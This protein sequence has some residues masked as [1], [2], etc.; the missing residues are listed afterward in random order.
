MKIGHRRLGFALL[1]VGMPAACGD[2]TPIN[3]GTAS[4][5]SAGGGPSSSSS[6]S[7]GGGGAGGGGGIGGAGGGGGGGGEQGECAA[8]PPG[9]IEPALFLDVFDGS[10]DFAFDG[11]GHILAKKGPNVISA[12]P[13]GQTTN[14][15]SVPGTVFGLRYRP[16][17]V[18]MAARPG[19]GVVV[20]ISTTGVVSSFV[21]GL[22]GPNGV[23]PD[24]AGNVWITDFAG[25]T[26][27][28]VNPDV[29]V[30]EIASGAPEV[31]QPNGV[32]FDPARKKLFYTNYS[33]G[34]IRS[35]DLATDG[36][37]PPVLV[38]QIAGASLD[39]LVMDACGNLYTVDN[40][41]KQL[42]RVRLDA[43][44]ALV[45]APELL[46]IFPDSVANAQFGAGAGFD[47]KTLYV[48]GDP[49]SV[50]TVPVGIAGAP[51]PAPP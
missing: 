21:S 48:S 7:A 47:P 13:S 37:S 22:E 6:S 40:G 45:G 50:Y 38:A 41:G 49:G 30:D 4:S 27:I 34:E 10:E 5:S 25:D 19:T 3:N 1:L 32:F 12:D 17:G 11:K 18:L 2:D 29:T 14:F 31:S 42:Y 15:A 20:Q 39:G 9:P 46:A 16:D 23:Y 36:A 26:V 35:V 51:V 24:A 33:A 28:R 8:L 43:G 44:G